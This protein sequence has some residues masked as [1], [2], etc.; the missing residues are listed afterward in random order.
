MKDFMQK[1]ANAVCDLNQF[2]DGFKSFKPGIGP[3]GEDEI[4]NLVMDRIGTDFPGFVIR[5]DSEAK[6]L[7][8][9]E[10]YNGITGRAATPDLVL[11]D[12]IIEFK[13]ARPIRDNGDIEDTWFKKCFEPFPS[14]YSTFIDV[15]KMCM[16][17]DRY[18]LEAKFQKW[19]MIIGF[20]RENETIYNLDTLFPSLFTYISESIVHRPVNAFLRESRL[21]G[22]RHPYHQVLKLFAFRY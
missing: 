8:G 13:I 14:S 16:F 11:Q 4:V 22:T 2:V 17:H 7:F 12:A 1:F 6:K 9:L 15:E 5:P 20:E 18:D 19:V 10:N 21:L 3:Y